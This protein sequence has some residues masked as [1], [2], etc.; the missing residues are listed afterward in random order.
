MLYL[1][2]LY[3]FHFHTKYL[4][5]NSICN[6]MLFYSLLCTLLSSCFLNFNYSLW[7]VSDSNKFQPLQCMILFIV[8]TCLAVYP[9][10]PKLT[11]TS[12]WTWWEW[13]GVLINNVQIS[14]PS[15]RFFSPVKGKNVTSV[16][17]NT[18]STQTG[19]LSRESVFYISRLV[20]IPASLDYLSFWLSRVFL[21]EYSFW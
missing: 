6:F 18:L 9:P 19:S 13:F 3:K 4:V 17:Q 15:K 20:T 16:L 21:N 2:F 12:N 7:H 8:S 11:H 1:F 14:W 10:P 5:C